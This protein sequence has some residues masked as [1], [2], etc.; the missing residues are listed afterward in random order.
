MLKTVEIPFGEWLPDQPDYKNPGCVMARNV[1]PIA[2]GYAPFRGRGTIGGAGTNACRGAMLFERSTGDTV[3]VAGSNDRLWVDV[4]GTTT[5]TEVADIGDAYWQFQRFGSRILAVSR[6]NDMYQLADVD[7]DTTWTV[8]SDAPSQAEVIGEVGSR[9]VVGNTSTNPYAIEWSALNDPITW[10]ATTTNYNGTAEL[11]QR[12]GE[13]TGIAGDRFPAI[14]QK[15]AVSRITRVGP[16]S[17][18]QIERI[19]EARG[20]IAPQSIAT[21]GMLTFFLAHDGFAVTNG[22]DVR[23]IGSSRVNRYFL[24]TVS[25]TDRFRTHAAVD[26]ANEC[27]VWSY[28]L[29]GGTGFEGLMIYSW[30]QDRW[31]TGVLDIDWLVPSAVSATSLDDL[32]ALYSSLDDIPY[33]L[34]ATRWQ[35]G[36]RRLATYIPISPE[37]ILMESGSTPVILDSGGTEVLYA[38]DDLV[39][40]TLYALDGDTL[41]ATF[42]TAEMQL[43]PGQRT[44]VNRVYPI[45]ENTAENTQAAVVTRNIKGGDITVSTRGTVN[46]A[47]FCP[48]RAEGRYTAIELTIPS[49]AE[50]KKAQGVQASVRTAGSR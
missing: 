6:N 31:S 33:S 15:Y 1:I 3:I 44:F 16:P 10:T 42:E 17:V 32:D 48:V 24:E 50:W 26:W 27:V 43:V 29:E 28:Y 8:V 35:A 49:G 22:S 36:V 12:Y 4:N 40:S 11:D 18:F 39:I 47:G 34:D 13:I 20:C 14:F 2:G 45:V 5:E 41:E 30:A 37:A 23:L 21:V 25:E 38:D 7:T 46:D 19:E 9:I